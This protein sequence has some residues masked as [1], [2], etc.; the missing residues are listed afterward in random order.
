[1]RRP[2]DVALPAA[3]PVDLSRAKGT[4]AKFRLFREQRYDS[5]F[6]SV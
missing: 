3:S 5:N 2:V 4:A 6:G 1:L